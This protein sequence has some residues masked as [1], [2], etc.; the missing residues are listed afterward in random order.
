M[1]NRACSAAFWLGFLLL[2]IISALASEKDSQ[3]V[4]QTLEELGWEGQIGQ[5][6]QIDIAVLLSDDGSELRQDLLDHY[7]GELGIGS[8][9]NNVA[10]GDKMWKIP[11]FRAA[12]VQ[13][14]QTAK[15][16]N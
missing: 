13:I 7:I 2:P 8:V 10:K 16:V 1:M 12:S 5:M 6:A 11:D 3:V 4:E 14:Q 9:L 15:K